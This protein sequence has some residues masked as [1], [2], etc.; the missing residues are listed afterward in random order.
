MAPLSRWDFELGDVMVSGDHVVAISVKG[1]RKGKQQVALRGA[2]IMR[3]NAA[4]QIVEGWGF[5]K[6][7]D[8]LDGFLCVSHNNNEHLTNVPITSKSTT[9]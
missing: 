9:G 1:E 5:Y 8:A 7:Q 6:D 2:H 3:L 4:G